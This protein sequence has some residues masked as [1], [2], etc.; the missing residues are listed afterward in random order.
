MTSTVTLGKKVPDFSASA[1]G[2]KQ[3]RLKDLKGKKVVLYFYPRDNTPGCTNEGQDFRDNYQAFQKT[4]TE[5]FGVSQDSL[6]SHENFRSKQNF[7]FDLISDE[8]GSLC[9]LF[10]V[11]KMKSMY[12]KQFEG[13]ER[14]TFLIDASGKLQAEWRKVKVPGHVEEVLEAAGKL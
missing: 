3:I 13:I 10:D 14:S 6:K 11:L 9:R 2:G 4:S 1:T 8:D 5:V 7:Q 12:G